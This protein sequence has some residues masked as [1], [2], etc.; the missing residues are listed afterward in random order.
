MLRQVLEIPGCWSATGSPR[1][2]RKRTPRNH[3]LN[4]TGK[5]DLN[6]KPWPDR[7]I[8]PRGPRVSKGRSEAG[9]Q[10]L[11][12]LNAFWWLASIPAIHSSSCQ[13]TIASSAVT[14]SHTSLACM[15]GSCVLGTSGDDPNLPR[16]F[17]WQECSKKWRDIVGSGCFL[18]ILLEGAGKGKEL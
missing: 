15:L 9:R 14:P 3:N 8:T 7:A 5:M 1:I 17:L 11:R 16:L 12:R 18:K 2:L 10:G 6:S 13:P 4:L